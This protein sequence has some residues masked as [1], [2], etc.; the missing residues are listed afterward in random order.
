MALRIF[1]S[2]LSRLGKYF[3]TIHLDFKEL[4]LNISCFIIIILSCVLPN[5]ITESFYDDND[6]D[7]DDH[8]CCYH[9]HFISSTII[10]IIIIIYITELIFSLSFA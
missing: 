9:H 7:D 3:A 10:I 5:L 2:P 6:D 4:L 1:T 8:Y